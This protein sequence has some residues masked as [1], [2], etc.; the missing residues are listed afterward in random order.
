MCNDNKELSCLILLSHQQFSTS[1]RGSSEGLV[2][3][4]SF[5]RSTILSLTTSDSSSV[6]TMVVERPE[7]KKL[8]LWTDVLFTHVQNWSIYDWLIDWLIVILCCSRGGQNSGWVVVNKILIQSSNLHIVEW[9][10]NNFHVMSFVW[11]SVSLLKLNYH[12]N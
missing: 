10:N 2:G 12:K 3:H 7:W 11:W 8:I 4:L 6:V 1:H 5:C 9:N